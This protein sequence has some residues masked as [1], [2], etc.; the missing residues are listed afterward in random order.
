MTERWNRYDKYVYC[1]G[2][3]CFTM[4]HFQ[5]YFSSNFCARAVFPTW[6]APVIKIIILSSSFYERYRIATIRYPSV[7]RYSKIC[8]GSFC[9]IFSGN[10]LSKTSASSSSTKYPCGGAY[11]PVTPSRYPGINSLQRKNEASDPSGSP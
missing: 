10:I 8:P 1:M 3:H 6:D 9:L 4:T 2:H 11:S 5:M 7:I